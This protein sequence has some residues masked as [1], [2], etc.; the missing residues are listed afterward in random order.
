M[1][2][3]GYRVWNISAIQYSFVLIKSKETALLFMKQDLLAPSASAPPQSD[4]TS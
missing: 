3:R 1:N 4:A 2:S